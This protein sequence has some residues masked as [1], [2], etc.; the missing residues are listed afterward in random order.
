MWF[1]RLLPDEALQP[2]PERLTSPT[3]NSLC[4]AA[5]RGEGPAAGLL[6]SGAPTD[7]QEARADTSISSSL[8]A[9]TS[10]PSAFQEAK[11]GN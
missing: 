5:L 2:T 8:Q 3:L 7:R 6:G 10:E 9:A 1:L 4:V 11:S